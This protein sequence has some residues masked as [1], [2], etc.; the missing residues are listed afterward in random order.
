MSRCVRRLGA[1]K[2]KRERLLA[3]L[4]LAD[5]AELE[6][7]VEQLHELDRLR[8][9]MAGLHAD[10]TSAIG[11]R[12]TEPEL[13]DVLNGE[14]K[15]AAVEQS[16]TAQRT[17]GR[18]HL[19]QLFEQR[20]QLREQLKSLAGDRRLSEKQVELGAVNAKIDKALERWR[21][22]AVCS[23]VLESVRE[24]YERERQPAALREAS[25][26]LRKLT[27]GRYQRVW[28]PLGHRVL[29]VD[30]AQGNNLP[31]EVLSRG[32]REQLFLALRLAIVRAY[33]E[34]GIRLP[35]VLDDVLVN[36]DLDRI[37][38]A[39]TVLRDFAREGHQVFVFTCHE[40]IADVFKVMQAQVR[41]LPD[42]MTVKPEYV[43][44]PVTPAAVVEPEPEPVIVEPPPAAPPA[45]PILQALPLPA[46]PPPEPLL[47]AEP[48]PEPEPAPP[49][50]PRRRRTSPPKP[51]MLRRRHRQQ[52]VET[53]RRAPKNSKANSPI[54]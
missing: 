9:E 48:L 1:V 28:T 53:V 32:T 8:Q 6:W 27:G 46:A 18:S 34:Q 33:A 29:R 42:N 20:G 19:E 16:L 23:S 54:A 5:A 51:A 47:Q 13:A 43:A 10:I 50:K 31:V 15:P 17:A 4:H 25:E 21:V 24:I 44:P 22:L 49:P 40:H 41:R 7:R 39:A 45:P 14:L 2:H 11:H 30:D 35:L 52:S 37:K 38:A 3:D 12:A 26:Y 36:F